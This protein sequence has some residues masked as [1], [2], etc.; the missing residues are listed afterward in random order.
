[1][2]SLQKL[3][4]LPDQTKVFCGHGPSTTIEREKRYNLY[5]RG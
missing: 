4:T 2:L 5:L 1:M 3:A